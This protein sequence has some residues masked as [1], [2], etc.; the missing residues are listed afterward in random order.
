M[1]N[2][3]LWVLGAVFGAVGTC[4][5]LVWADDRPTSTTKDAGDRVREVEVAPDTNMIV[6]DVWTVP[7]SGLPNVL[8]SGLVHM[9]PVPRGTV[10]KRHVIGADGAER[11]VA[12]VERRIY[13]N[14]EGK[15]FL[16]LGGGKLVADDITT[17][18]P[19]NILLGRYTFQVTG[20]VDPAGQGGPYSVEFGL[21]SQCPQSVRSADRPGLIIDGTGG[22]AVFTDDAP[23]QIE[24]VVPGDVIARLPTNFLLG[25]KLSHDNVGIVLG[26]PAFEGHSADKWDFP[27]F[28]CASFLGGFPDQPHASFNAEIFD[29]EDSGETHVEYKAQRLS[30]PTFNPGSTVWLLDDLQLLTPNCEMVAYEV[31]IK[32]NARYDFEFRGSCNGGAIAGTDKALINSQDDLRLFRVLLNEPV[33]LPQRPW[34][35]VKV[36]NTVGGTVVAGTRPTIGD[37]ADFFGV[38]NAENACELET[39][40]T[41]IRASLHLTVTCAGAAPKGAC[42]D[43]FLGKCEGGSDAR[44]SCHLAPECDMC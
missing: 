39:V 13:S 7:D 11:V 24:W 22:T 5:G 42:C 37:S 16:A 14:T 9:A 18:A 33:A 25:V 29:R 30:G 4:A 6:E 41:G 3:T 27:P 38:I 31:A 10:F 2:R 21:Y 15:L 12:G 20:Q 36:S 26:A 8:S 32:G 34:F 40:G 1:R 17:T 19:H 43:M 35:A 23:R 44:K 28:V